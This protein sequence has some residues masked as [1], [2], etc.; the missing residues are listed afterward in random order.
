VCLTD[1]DHFIEFGKHSG[2]V[3]TKFKELGLSLCSKL[4]PHL[5]PAGISCPPVLLM[6]I[7]SVVAIRPILNVPVLSTVFVFVSSNIQ[8]IYICFLVPGFEINIVHSFTDE[9]NFFFH[10][11]FISPHK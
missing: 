3:N 8:C 5:F 6:I 7:C 2:M 1:K 9:N 4:R 10:T 11:F